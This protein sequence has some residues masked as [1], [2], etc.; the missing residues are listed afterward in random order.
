MGGG[1][2]RTSRVGGG[3]RA[4]PSRV[5]GGAHK[6]TKLILLDSLLQEAAYFGSLVKNHFRVYRYFGFYEPEKTK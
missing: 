2:G 1:G 6:A 3:A 4:R 5:G